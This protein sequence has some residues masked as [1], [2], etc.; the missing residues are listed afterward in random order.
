[1]PLS[2]RPHLL[3]VVGVVF[4]AVVWIVF[5]PTIDHQSIQLVHGSVLLIC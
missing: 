3:P 1:M 2:C 5:D 4:N